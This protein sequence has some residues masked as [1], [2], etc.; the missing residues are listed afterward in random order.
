MKDSIKKVEREEKA[1][2]EIPEITKQD[3]I[4]ELEIFFRKRQLQN[5]ILKKLAQDLTQPGDT[6]TE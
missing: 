4:I 3:E 5:T 2:G 6:E 1:T